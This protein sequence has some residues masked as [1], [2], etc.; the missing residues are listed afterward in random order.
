MS[1]LALDAVFLGA[2]HFLVGAHEGEVAQGRGVDGT[3]R[4]VNEK[5][6][7]QQLLSPGQFALPALGLADRCTRHFGWTRQKHERN[8]QNFIW[9]I[10]Y[11]A[12]KGRVNGT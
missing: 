8:L 3:Y 7:L 10:E 11:W 2:V 1:P 4:I 5:E 6:A 12:K 9:L